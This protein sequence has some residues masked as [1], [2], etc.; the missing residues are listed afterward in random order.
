MKHTLKLL[1]VTIFYISVTSLSYAQGGIKIGESFPDYTF[2]DTDHFKQ[3]TFSTKDFRGKWLVLD[4]WSVWCGTCISSMPKMSKMQSELQDQVQI[5]M[6]GKFY[7]NR[8]SDDLKAT[9]KLFEKVRK[10]KNL[11][12]TVA[13]DTILSKTLNVGGM[14]DIFVID[15]NGILRARVGG[16]F[17]LSVLKQIMNGNS[18]ELL[19]VM[20]IKGKEEFDKKF[21]NRSERQN[22]ILRNDL[23][24]PLLSPMNDT[25]KAKYLYR[26]I[27]LPHSKEFLNGGRTEGN[28]RLEFINW[29][30]VELYRLAYFGRHYW[31]MQTWKQDNDPAALSLHNEYWLDPILAIT[32]S[33]K[34]ISQYKLDNLYTYSLW[35]PKIYQK[36]IYDPQPWLI[37]NR[38]DLMKN[39]QDALKVAFGYNVSIEQRRKPYYRLVAHNDIRDKIQ[40]KGGETKRISLGRYKGINIQ[41]SPISI[42]IEYFFGV[43]GF[44]IRMPFVDE[45]NIDY[46]IDIE[47]QGGNL[48]EIRR[49][50]RKNG[51]DLVEG[52]KDM[53]VLVISDAGSKKFD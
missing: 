43:P 37:R 21:K 6:V 28:G 41:N 31:H 35:Y 13:Y 46:N 8:T 11:N 47:L 48:E 38:P 25:S 2:L 19:N 16:D 39:M 32:D 3:K 5:V 15:P 50:L 18:E 17:N 12:L 34:F 40:T 52:E 29:P 30:L 53:K 45:T 22:N 24:Y 33:S 10:E 20:N 26:S 44:N 27:I 49:S 1:I 36:D 14:P 7:N 42:L 51:L 9:K 23:D 4:Y